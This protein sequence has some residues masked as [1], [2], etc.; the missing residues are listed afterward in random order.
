MTPAG[1]PGL[2]DRQPLRIRRGEEEEE[3]VPGAGRRALGTEAGTRAGQAAFQVVGVGD[4]PLGASGVGPPELPGRACVSACCVCCVSGALGR[5][6]RET[7]G[8]GVRRCR[9]RAS[10]PSVRTL[11]VRGSKISPSWSVFSI[12]HSWLRE[13]VTLV[14]KRGRKLL[15]ALEFHKSKIQRAKS[16]RL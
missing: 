3:G 14:E 1:V 4:L 2:L 10:W 8:T 15:L 9:G 6:G 5:R 13:E 7:A 16:L 11:T 12:L